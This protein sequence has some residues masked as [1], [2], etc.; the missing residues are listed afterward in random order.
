MPSPT[1]GL[2]GGLATGIFGRMREH[3][4]EQRQMDL[5]ERKNALTSLSSLLEHATPDTRPVIYKQMADVM[6]LKGKHRG[7]WDMLTGQGRDDYHQQLSSQLDNVFGNIMGPKAYEAATTVAPTSGNQEDWGDETSPLAYTPPA[8]KIA[9]R[10]PIAEHLEA[11]KSQYG[12]Q[13]DRKSA[14]IE[15]R[16]QIA[17]KNAADNDARD[18]AN[19]KDIEEQRAAL[20][21]FGPILQRAQALS[22]GKAPT[23]EAIEQAAKEHAD[24]YGLDID[25]LKAQIEFLTTG[26]KRNLALAQSLGEGGAGRPMTEN[27]TRVFDANQRKQAA[28]TF[29][30]W[31]NFRGQVNQLD[32]QHQGIRKQIA[33]LA[34]KNGAGFNE[35]AVYGQSDKPVFYNLKTNDPVDPIELG[36]TDKSLQSLL[37]QLRTLYANKNKAYEELK[38]RHKT[39][40]SDFKGM[41]N[42]TNEWD[43]TPNPEV[44]GLAPAGA[45]R[46]GN[47]SEWKVP[48]G[49]SPLTNPATEFERVSSKPLVEGSL[50]Q[51]DKGKKFKVGKMKKRLGSYFVYELQPVE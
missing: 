4:D 46:T 7:V 41:Y 45:P 27:Q 33:D 14:E 25:K 50:Y 24:K 17:A 39:L 35:A 19:R 8:G 13:N 21:A 37:G 42:S 28:D 5:E 18:F 23:P 9:L 36:V 31:T 12:L 2:F 1:A 20:K 15:L 6:K 11:L 10:D 40:M 48:L 3:E 44:G 34:A 32:T 49:P 29:K 51:D 38:G 30:E 43:V 47:P 26:S 22:G 16:G